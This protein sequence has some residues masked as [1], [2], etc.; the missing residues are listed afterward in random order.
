MSHITSEQEKEW[1]A[2]EEQ[3]ITSYHN[4]RKTGLHI[5][6]DEMK[7]WANG[8]NKDTSLPIPTCHK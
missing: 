4:M 5:A 3:A 2:F 8:L 7:A 6:Q 1:R